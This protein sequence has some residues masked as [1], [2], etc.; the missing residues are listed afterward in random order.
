MQE[1]LRIMIWINSCLGGFCPKLTCARK[2]SKWMHGNVFI[3]EHFCVRV[4]YQRFGLSAGW[5]N[6]D[7]EG[8]VCYFVFLGDNGQTRSLQPAAT[9]AC[10]LFAKRPE[11]DDAERLQACFPE[12]LRN[13]RPLKSGQGALDFVQL[14]RCQ[15]LRLA[16]QET[17]RRKQAAQSQ[18]KQKRCL[19][20][21]G[22]EELFQL[23]RD[24]EPSSRDD[25]L[26]SRLGDAGQ[27]LDDR[28]RPIG[29]ARRLATSLLFV[30]TH[31]ELWNTCCPKVS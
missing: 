13:P 23:L 2:S 18:R 31:R 9:S 15:Y 6:P 24:M 19:S 26:R 25:L 8:S 16:P 30:K 28:A 3:P 4:V 11:R 5:S 17:E 20:E 10:G 1:L 22:N 29:M 7:L 27:S 12:Y 14:A 21:I